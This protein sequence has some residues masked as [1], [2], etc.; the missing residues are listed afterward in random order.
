MQNEPSVYDRYHPKVRKPEKGLKWNAHASR[1]QI[2]KQLKHL[3][4]ISASAQAVLD[5][6][7]ESERLNNALMDCSNSVRW[8]QDKVLSEL[9][10]GNAYLEYKKDM[11]P[12]D[13][14]PATI[15]K[16]VVMPAFRYGLLT[17]EDSKLSFMPFNGFMPKD[18]VE[19]FVGENAYHN[20]AK[21]SIMKE[22]PRRKPS[23]RTGPAG[24]GFEYKPEINWHSAGTGEFDITST[25][26]ID[27]AGEDLFRP[28]YARKNHPEQSL[29]KIEWAVVRKWKNKLRPEFPTTRESQGRK[30]G[31]DYSR[32]IAMGPSYSFGRHGLFP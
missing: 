28:K 26:W 8:E 19:R 10:Y 21:G 29:P 14:T 22:A 16:Y 15:P 12:I 4:V 20:Y 11:L 32:K 5:Q 6:I 17:V 30:R 1:G 3:S 23:K 18:L 27:Y 24:K 13:L 7:I 31:E 2:R 25:D 9:P